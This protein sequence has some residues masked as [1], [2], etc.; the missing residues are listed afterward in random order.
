MKLITNKGPFES[1]AALR[2]A[3][4]DACGT[5]KA[6]YRELLKYAG[7]GE[8]DPN[9]L[10]ASEVGYCP[11][12]QML[13]LSGAP[14][15]VQAM[16]TKAAE[17]QMFAFGYFAHYWTYAAMEWAGILTGFEQNVFEPPW[18]GSFDAMFLPDVNDPREWLWGGK[19]TRPNAKNYT[20]SL[21]KTAH[22]LQEGTYGTKVVVEGAVIEYIDRGG[23]KPAIECVLNR[24]AL[25][26]WSERALI[27]MND[28]EDWK[29]SRLLGELPPI[30][31]EMFVA[32]YR[33]NRNQ[34]DKDIIAATWNCSWEC[35]YCKYN[36]TAMPKSSSDKFPPTLSSSPCQPHWHAPIYLKKY[37]K[38]TGWVYIEQTTV[39]ERA[40]DAFLA[41]QPQTVPV[42]GGQD[43]DE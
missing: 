33:K 29:M 23:S 18:S 36:H 13:R 39:N 9:L 30:L 32:H 10:H 22:C 6:F 43:E 1:F 14:A 28:N 15:K 37:T 42:V 40:I 12:M 38:K 20:E 26:T 25:D 16:A 24:Q 35:G 34:P 11:R 5:D 7:E 3:F 8:W 2:Y 19:T 21:P 41:A 17:G 4:K 31:E 27:R